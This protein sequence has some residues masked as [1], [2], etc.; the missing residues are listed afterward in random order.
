M[1]EKMKISQVIDSVKYLIYAAVFDSI[2]AF[3]KERVKPVGE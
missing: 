2:A 3:V 1:K